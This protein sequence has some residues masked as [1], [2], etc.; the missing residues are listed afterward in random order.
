MQQRLRSSRYSLSIHPKSHNEQHSDKLLR[1]NA[2]TVTHAWASAAG[3]AAA[4]ASRRRHPSLAGTGVQM[5][6]GTRIGSNTA[7]AFCLPSPRSLTRRSPILRSELI[8][9]SNFPPSDGIITLLRANTFIMR[10]LS[11]R[12]LKLVKVTLQIT[13]QSP[14]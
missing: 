11:Q 3:A 1:L 9:H 5:P 13:S 14:S 7:R 4:R 2:P 10:T 8:T 12:V 6:H